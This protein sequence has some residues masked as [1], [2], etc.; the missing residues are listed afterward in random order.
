MNIWYDTAK[1]AYL[2]EYLRIYWTDFRY[3]FSLYESILGADDRSGHLFFRY[4]KGRC[5]GNHIILGESI[6]RGLILPA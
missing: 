5:H 6:E 1:M 3:F 4:R 2:V